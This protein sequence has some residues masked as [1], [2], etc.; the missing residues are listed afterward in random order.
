MVIF[1]LFLGNNSIGFGVSLFLMC[2]IK[3]ISSFNNF[4]AFETTFIKGFKNELYW[5]LIKTIVFNVAF[6]HFLASMLL[7]MAKLNEEENW[8]IAHSIQNSDWNVQY[9]WAYYWATTV[10]MTI[11]FGDIS[12]TNHQEGIV[13]AFLELFSC[14]VLAYNIS[15]IGSIISALRSAQN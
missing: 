1:Y 15:E 12:A 11:G 3:L 6:A 9:M 8:L 10:M 14:I 2:L 4:V 13:L 7:A 5:K